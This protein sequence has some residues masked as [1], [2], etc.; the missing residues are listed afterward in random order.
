MNPAAGRTFGVEAVV[1][2]FRDSD[3]ESSFG[4]TS[5]ADGSTL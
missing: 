5:S 2:G 1:E 4:M 3:S